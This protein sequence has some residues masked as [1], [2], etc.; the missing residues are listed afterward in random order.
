MCNQVKDS[1]HQAAFE[2]LGEIETTNK[3]YENWSKEIEQEVQKNFI[4]KV[5]KYKKP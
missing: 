3:K 1:I 5:A 2:A 4:L